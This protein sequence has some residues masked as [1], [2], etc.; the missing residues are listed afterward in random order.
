MKIINYF[1]QFGFRSQLSTTLAF[2]SLLDT[3]NKG[4]EDKEFVHVQFLDLS[5]A[6]D[7]V[8]HN[9]LVDKLSFYN[10]SESSKN[11]ILSY[12]T[13]RSQYV[14]IN[15]SKSNR[16][17]IKFGV[18]QGSVLGP[19]LFLIYVNDLPNS[20]TLSKFTLF[21]DDTTLAQ[22]HTNI[23]TLLKEAR[24]SLTLVQDWFLSN[25]LVLNKD[26]TETMIFSLKHH[27][28]DAKY[29][30]CVKFLGVVLDS[31]LTW[32]KHTELVCNNVSGNIY[33]IW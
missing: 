28:L 17:D 3:I 22:S 12:I 30:N 32:D 20:T 10:F 6:F 16:I 33:I 29:F 7:C 24:N 5:K 31:K 15:N 13:D 9:I 21:A 2:N 14:N 8:S 23:S 11:L 1:S 19:V 18:P 27:T 26:K 4:F 25:Q